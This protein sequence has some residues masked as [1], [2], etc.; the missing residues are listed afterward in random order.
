MTRFSSPYCNMSY[1]SNS[2]LVTRPEYAR[3][4]TTLSGSNSVEL[5]SFRNF[6]ASFADSLTLIVVIQLLS[7]G[8][9]MLE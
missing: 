5:A 7:H 2:H 9:Q 4:V 3:A 1:A 8:R 6:K